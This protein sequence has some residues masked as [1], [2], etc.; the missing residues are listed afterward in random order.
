MLLLW[1]WAALAA[2]GAFGLETVSVLLLVPA[3]LCSIHHLDAPGLLLVS[4]I[5]YPNSEE[6]CFFLHLGLRN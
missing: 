2:A 4:A 5:V 6:W 3:G 1:K